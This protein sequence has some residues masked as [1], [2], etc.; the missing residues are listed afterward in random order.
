MKSF[1]VCNTVLFLMTGAAYFQSAFMALAQNTPPRMQSQ[2]SGGVGQ[3]TY[4]VGQRVDYIENGKWF[5]AVIIEVR[6]DSGD[7][8]DRKIYSPY[9]V[10][11]LGYVGDHWV[12][13][14]DF[15]D[16]RSQLRAAGAGPVEVVPGGEVNDDVLNALRGASKKSSQPAVKQYNCGIGSPIAIT[17]VGTYAGGT[18]TFDAS[19]STLSFHGGDYDGQ[20]AVYEMSY[21]IARLH[22]VGP[23]GRLIIDCD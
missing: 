16:R 19:S 15:A 22:I 18:Y 10:H 14:A 13:C 2:P 3:L 23:S 7:H 12:C 20:R 21:G 11:A 1:T 17:G 4:K 6:D 9:R 8:L 5:K